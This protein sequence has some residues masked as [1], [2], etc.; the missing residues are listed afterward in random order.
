MGDGA[1]LWEVRTGR[2][3]GGN[4][5]P[6]S[7][8]YVNAACGVIAA[9]VEALCARQ[10]FM[11]G[12]PSAANAIEYALAWHA[13]HSHVTS[14]IEEVHFLKGRFL[15]AVAVGSSLSILFS[16]SPAT[17]PVQLTSLRGKTFPPPT[18][19]LYSHPK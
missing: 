6:I 3:S 1:D 14:S 8:S 16:H 18:T 2:V 12:F 9:R 7:E 15:K 17:Y 13:P 4:V 11:M 19:K 5:E 10:P